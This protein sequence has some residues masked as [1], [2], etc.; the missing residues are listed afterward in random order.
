MSAAMAGGAFLRAFARRK[1]GNARSPMSARGGG[2]RRS[3][4]SSTLSDASAGRVWAKVSAT[5]VGSEE[6]I[7]RTLPATAGVVTRARAWG[8]ATRRFGGEGSSSGSR[9]SAMA[10][11]GEVPSRGRGAAR[12][13]AGGLGL[14]WGGTWASLW[15]WSSCSSGPGSLSARY[16]TSSDFAT[17]VSD[18]VFKK[19]SGGTLDC[20]VLRRTCASPLRPTST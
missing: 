10:G 20:S 11:G 13:D 18:S 2:A 3:A 17:I 9:W 1:Q 4:I 7:G 15:P 5:R 8:R 19:T 12:A 16:S 14:G 6:R